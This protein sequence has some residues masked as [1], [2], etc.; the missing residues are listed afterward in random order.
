MTARTLG[1]GKRLGND[2]E[3]ALASPRADTPWPDTEIIVT[4][5]D[6]ERRNVRQTLLSAGFRLSPHIARFPRTLR[7]ND[8]KP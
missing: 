8:Q 5:H 2:R 1:G 7:S 6:A 4:A 3:R